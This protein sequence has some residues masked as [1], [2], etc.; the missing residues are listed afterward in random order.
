[1]KILVPTLLILVVSACASTAGDVNLHRTSSDS[2]D[3]CAAK[4]G[5]MVGYTSAASICEWPA[6][7]SGKPCSDS[8][9]CQGYCVP[10]VR[11]DGRPHEVGEKSSGQCS[12]S[13][14]N[15]KE[16]NCEEF[17]RHGKVHS[18]GCID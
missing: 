2:V 9:Q 15:I 4:G 8:D 6:T 5:R 18:I 13:R 16:P 14:G 7:D 10:G 12:A 17:I 1:M 3:S 11:S